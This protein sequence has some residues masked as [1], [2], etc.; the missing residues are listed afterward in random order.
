MK[1]SFVLAAMFAVAL[2][3]ASVGCNGGKTQKAENVDSAAVDSVKDTTV[4]EKAE[5]EIPEEEIKAAVTE[6]CVAMFKADMSFDNSNVFDKY[7]TPEFKA[8]VK[9][10]RDRETRTG[11]LLLDYDIILNAQD[12]PDNAKPKVLSV[13]VKSATEAV[14]EVQAWKGNNRTVTLK[15]VDGKWLVDD[16]SGERANLEKLLK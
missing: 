12:Y 10:V 9:K 11:D 15:Q 14:A 16:I 3:L 13:D 7:F 2:S 5:P 1:K 8:L 6:T 4:V